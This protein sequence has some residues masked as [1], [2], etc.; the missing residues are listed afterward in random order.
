LKFFQVL[1][2]LPMDRAWAFVSMLD[3][4]QYNVKEKVVMARRCYLLAMH[5]AIIEHLLVEA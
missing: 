3:F 2:A 4:Y 5:Q 1:S